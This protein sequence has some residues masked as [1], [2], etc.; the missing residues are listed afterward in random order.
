MIPAYLAGLRGENLA[1]LFVVSGAPT[2]VASFIMAKAMDSDGD[3]AAGIVFLA[4]VCSALTLSAGILVLRS[5]GQ[6]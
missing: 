4:T 2:A 3:L 6:L 5:M 1:V